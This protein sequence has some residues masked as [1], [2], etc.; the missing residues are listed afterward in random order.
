MISANAA[1]AQTVRWHM[2]KTGEVASIIGFTLLVSACQRSVPS[3]A[4]PGN[5]EVG[6]RYHYGFETSYLVPCGSS[7]RWWIGSEDSALNSIMLDQLRALEA[8]PDSLLHGGVVFARFRGDSLAP[9]EHGHLG[10]YRRGLRL[11]G[12]MLFRDTTSDDCRDHP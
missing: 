5:K 7:E 1:Q 8:H 10:Q 12:V 6:G 2:N 9:G 4:P 11:R 3:Q